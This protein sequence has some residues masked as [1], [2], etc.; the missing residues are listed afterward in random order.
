MLDQ[1]STNT[2]ISRHPLVCRNLSTNSECK[3]MTGFHLSRTLVLN[4][5]DQTDY[6]PN[7]CGLWWPTFESVNNN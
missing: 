6:I 2:E 7:V 5:L 4:S 3:P 1:Y